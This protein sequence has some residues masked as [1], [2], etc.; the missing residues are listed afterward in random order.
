MEAHE[1]P[2]PLRE[3]LLF[4]AVAGL[5]VPLLQRLRV[6]PVFGFLA[7]GALLGPHG[8]GGLGDRLPWLARA[9]F[10]DRD[11]VEV[12]AQL[13]LLFLMFSIGLELSLERLRTLRRWVFGAGGAQIAATT[14][15]IGAVLWGLLGVPPPAAAVVGAVFAFSSTA[16]A[17][18]LLAE[19][20]RLGTPLGRVSF[21]VLLMQDLA[22]VPLLL[23]VTVLG[24]DG[25]TAGASLL[26]ALGWA[27]T[28]GAAAMVLIF[29]AGRR[30]L[31][32]AFRR[33][34]VP[35]RPDT[36]VALTLLASLGIAGATGA[37]GM[38]PAL[39]ALLAGM[40]LAE[41]EFRHEIEATLEPFNLRTAVEPAPAPISSTLAGA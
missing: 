33:L 21:S 1:S 19:R 39:G 27:L 8:I 4:L 37:I 23:A 26:L 14:A 38:S 2:V 9:G 24:G 31:Q 13:G 5:L 29:V 34:I 40:L 28:Q 18:Q 6:N 20:D 41:T 17:L 15:A 32:P 3:A 12:P 10:A 7:A 16:V 11:A 25:G 30:V 22:V 36:F 35:G